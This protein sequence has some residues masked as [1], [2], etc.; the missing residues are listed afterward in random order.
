MLL[1]Y[2][3]PAYRYPK[4]ERVCQLVF[5]IALGG[6]GWHCERGDTKGRASVASLVLTYIVTVG[7]T[8]HSALCKI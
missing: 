5:V 1:V 8:A 7:L 2:Y 3:H 4:D 6:N